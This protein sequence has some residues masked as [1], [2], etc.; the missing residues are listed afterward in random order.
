MHVQRSLISI[1]NKQSASSFIYDTRKDYNLDAKKLALK[2]QFRG[3]LRSKISDAKKDFYIPIP[4]MQYVLGG[5]LHNNNASHFLL[6]L[7]HASVYWTSIV[8]MHLTPQN[9]RY[10]GI[11]ENSELTQEADE[12]FLQ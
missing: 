11:C 10:Y 2:K 12:V 9:E 5:S 6:G 3:T 1:K 4:I 7:Y 8:L